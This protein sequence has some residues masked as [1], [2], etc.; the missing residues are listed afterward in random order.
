VKT[1]LLLAALASLAHS[2]AA[3][4]DLRNTGVRLSLLRSA[5]IAFP[6]IH[7]P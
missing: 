2:A 7:A 3:V 6:D 5:M 1:T 4:L